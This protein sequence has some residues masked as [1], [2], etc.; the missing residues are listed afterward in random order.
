MITPEMAG[1]AAKMLGVDEQT[2]QQGMATAG[3]LL[4]QLLAD[5]TSTPEGAQ[6]VYDTVTKTDAAG[7]LEGI[8]GS[9]SQAASGAAGAP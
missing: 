3:P 1:Q 2:V 5:K 9:L 7:G 6:Q 4:Q 8:L